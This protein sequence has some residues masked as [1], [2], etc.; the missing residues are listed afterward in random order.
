VSYCKICG[1]ELDKNAVFC[2]NCGSAV[3]KR[4]AVRIYTASAVAPKSV[5]KT[6]IKLP[7]LNPF[8]IVVT[9]FKAILYMMFSIIAVIATIMNA[10]K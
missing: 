1:F 9:C 2:E 6:R 3:S 10:F 5:R 4:E 7:S 8:Y